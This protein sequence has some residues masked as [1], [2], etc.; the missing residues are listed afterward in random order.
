MEISLRCR[1]TWRTS[2]N[3]IQN[4]VIR[5]NM[6]VISSENFENKDCIFCQLIKDFY[7]IDKGTF[8]FMEFVEEIIYVYFDKNKEDA[9]DFDMANDVWINKKFRFEKF[10]YNNKIVTEHEFN[11]IRHDCYRNNDFDTWDKIVTKWYKD[12]YSKRFIDKI[13]T[14]EINALLTCK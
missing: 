2:L 13:I 9:R 12:Y 3:T 11:N 5:G 8:I 6:D 14:I 7:G 4:E 1:D 10:L